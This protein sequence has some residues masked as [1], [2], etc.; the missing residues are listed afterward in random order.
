M[1]HPEIGLS[2]CLA[3]PLSVEPLAFEVTLPDS[4]SSEKVSA[5][6][7][8]RAQQLGATE[9]TNATKDME[10]KLILKIVTPSLMANMFL[11]C[12]DVWMLKHVETVI[13]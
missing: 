11:S 3:Q 13:F 4:D 6:A 12:L 2:R 8:G 5:E 10:T 9:Q 1:T 7:A